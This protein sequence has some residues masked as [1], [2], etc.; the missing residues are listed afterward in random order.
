MMHRE[1][2]VCGLDSLELFQVPATNVALE[3]SK[4]VEYNPVSSTLQSDT[5]PIEFDIKGQGDKYL[6]LSQ[7]YL[8]LC[9][10]FTKSDGTN[11][12][13]DSSTS[14][15]VN[16]ILHSLFTEIDVSLNGKVISPGTDTYPY[17]AYLEKLF[18]YKPRTHTTQMKTCSLWEKDTAEHMDDL[19]AAAELTTKIFDVKAKEDDENAEEIEI[20]AADLVLSYPAGSGN[21]GLSKRHKAIDDS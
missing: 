21:V 6:D 16:N 18:S 15:P 12:T 10:K 1:S 5:A 14:T 7:T 3:E 11:L 9:C 13:G 19:N 17:K 2:C 8:Q 20:D 4:W